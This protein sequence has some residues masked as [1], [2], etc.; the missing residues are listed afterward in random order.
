MVNVLS[1]EIVVFNHIVTLKQHQAFRLEVIKDTDMNETSTPVQ[2]CAHSLQASCGNCRLKCLCLPISLHLDDLDRLERIIQRGRPLHKGEM[3]YRARVS[4]QSL[5]A[6]RSGA[7]KTSTLNER[8]EEQITG[9]Y[10]PGELVGLDGLAESAYTNSAEALETTSVCEIPFHRIEELSSKIPSLQRHL[11]QL[12]SREITHEQQLL[13]MLNISRAE[14]RVA[15]LLMSMS[16]R[17]QRCHLSASQFR[18]P[19]SRSDMGNFLGLTIETV[20]RVFRRLQEDGILAV[21]NKEVQILDMPRLQ[22]LGS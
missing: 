6:I 5:Y 16:L 2:Q 18:L 11:F 22:A 9:F 4:F 15:A 14:E 3:L 17:H 13:A 7:V 12:F 20:S 1:S 19:M 21:H 10:F 8:G